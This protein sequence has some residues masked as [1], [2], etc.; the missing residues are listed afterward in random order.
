M[1]GH[2][3]H[4]TSAFM[5]ATVVLIVPAQ[6]CRQEPGAED[7][8]GEHSGH[9]VPAHKPRNLPDA[10][11]RL[12]EINIELT[13]SSP[14]RDKPAS[15]RDALLTVAI[16]IASWLPEIAADC[17]LPE[18]QWNTVNERSRVIAE[19]YEF[20]KANPGSDV[21]KLLEPAIHAV[22]DLEGMIATTDRAVFDS[23]PSLKLKP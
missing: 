9:I 3:K 19:A 20:L 8:K 11:R 22:I 12:W 7:G 4:I 15:D 2:A 13:Q 18:T 21:H 16:D 6:G 10:A 17:D 23:D 1:V 14:S 5:I